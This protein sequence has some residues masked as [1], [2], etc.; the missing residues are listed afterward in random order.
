MS[1]ESA[2][3]FASQGRALRIRLLLPQNGKAVAVSV[4]GEPAE[5][6]RRKEEAAARETGCKD[7]DLRQMLLLD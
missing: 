1:S 4:I 6:S 3:P 5:K 2:R 7:K